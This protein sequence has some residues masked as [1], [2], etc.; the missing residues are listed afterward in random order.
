MGHFV[1]FAPDPESVRSK[2][3]VLKKIQLAWPN[4][5]SFLLSP[6]LHAV[7]IEFCKFYG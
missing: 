4:C 6:G 2:E 7:F 1:T 5:K 3:N